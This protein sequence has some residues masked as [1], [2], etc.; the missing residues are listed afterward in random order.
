T[1]AA[2][3]GA[4]ALL[5]YVRREGYVGELDGRR[6]TCELRL[7]RHGLLRCRDLYFDLS[8]RAE[9]ACLGVQVQHPDLPQ[10]FARLP[11]TGLLVAALGVE[12]SDRLYAQEQCPMWKDVLERHGDLDR[13]W[14][15]RAPLLG[16]PVG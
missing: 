8:R 9:P 3:V 10:S 14:N 1:R 13:R 2:P 5:I 11:V 15:H 16:L 7:R 12:V 6:I 4:L